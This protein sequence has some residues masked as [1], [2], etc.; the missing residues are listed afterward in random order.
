[1]LTAIVATVVAQETASVVATELRAV[2]VQHAL[3][4][5]VAE[6]AS[7]VAKEHQP[8]EDGET[9]MTGCC[10]LRATASRLLKY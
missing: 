4:V 2:L 8:E 7:A 3:M 5:V 6:I 1:M 9:S 10:S